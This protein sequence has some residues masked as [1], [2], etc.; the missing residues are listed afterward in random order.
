VFT[1]ADAQRAGYQ[2]PEIRRLLSPGRWVRLRRGIYVTA[3]DL[4]RASASPARRH[5]LDCLAAPLALRRPSAVVSHTSAARLW[6][7]PVRRD[8]PRIVRLTDSGQ[9]RKGD[10][11]LVVPAPVRPDERARSGPVP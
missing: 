2:H 8:A 5:R 3:D 10:G 11:F 6:G 9:W 4:T 7:F 1:A